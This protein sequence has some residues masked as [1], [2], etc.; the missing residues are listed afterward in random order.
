M[1]Y[2]DQH[3]D[4]SYER[5]KQPIYAPRKDIAKR[6]VNGR[7]P[8]PEGVGTGLI[9]SEA[10]RRAAE[11]WMKIQP[12]LAEASR[13]QA[14]FGG[15]DSGICRGLPWNELTR[16]ECLQ[17]VDIWYDEIAMPELRGEKP[18]EQ[19][20]LDPLAHMPGM[21]EKADGSA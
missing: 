4:G 14:E 13:A 17:I 18:P 12:Q 2:S 6:L 7:L 8:G 9:M 3:H 5:L 1:S 19:W 10:T 16:D 11:W 15:L 21:T 20:V